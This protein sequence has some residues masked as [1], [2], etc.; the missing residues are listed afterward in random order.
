MPKAIYLFIK[1]CIFNEERRLQPMLSRTVSSFH[2][3]AYF[4]QEKL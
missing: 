3:G 2:S 4:Q 1:M